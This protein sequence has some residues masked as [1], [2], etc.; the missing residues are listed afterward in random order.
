VLINAGQEGRK[1]R[2]QEVKQYGL[3]DRKIK[4][5]LNYKQ[6]E[7]LLTLPSCP[8]DFLPS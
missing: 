2:G 3:K 6:L 8:L 1:A 7:I 4:R 5:V